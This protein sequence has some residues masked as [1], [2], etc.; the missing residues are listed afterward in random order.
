MKIAVAI[1]TIK[2]ENLFSVSVNQFTNLENSVL[3]A[4]LWMRGK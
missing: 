1:V 4:M 3:F 2:T